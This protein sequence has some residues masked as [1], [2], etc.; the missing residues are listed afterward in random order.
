MHKGRL[1]VIAVLIGTMLLAIQPQEK[2]GGSTSTTQTAEIDQLL[3]ALV[4]INWFHNVRPLNLTSEQ[5]DR[6]L[7]AHEKAFKRL[8]EVVQQE[9]QTLR[10][11]KDEI[12]RVREDASRGK[13][14]PK[15]FIEAMRQ[16]EQD[17]A[18]RRRELRTQV[19]TEI[20]TELK[21]RFTEEQMDYMVKR[22]REVLQASGVNAEKLD[23]D[24]LYMFFVENVFLIERAPILLR[25][26]KQ[27]NL[28]R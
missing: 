25:E 9:A 22:S 28:A 10:S 11:R 3:T 26:W 21:P 27:K 12:L 2:S 20:G 17:A 24:Q 14:V 6:L 13:S 1:T 7:A 5:I 4:D 8:N 23:R 18:R 19:I 16:L 15:E